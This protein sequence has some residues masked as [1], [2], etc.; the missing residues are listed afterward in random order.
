MYI[1]QG[2]STTMAGNYLLVSVDRKVFAT[3]DSV[4]QA[5]LDHR[6]R[7]SPTC[8]GPIPHTTCIHSIKRLI[9]SYLCPLLLLIGIQLWLENS[10]D[11]LSLSALHIHPADRAQVFDE[12]IETA[13]AIL[14]ETFPR[15]C[16][17]AIVVIVKI[18][19]PALDRHNI[20][21]RGEGQCNSL[22][23]VANPSIEYYPCMQPS[24][25]P[26]TQPIDQQYRQ[27]FH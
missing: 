6:R 5:I 16:G 19:N 14:I 18:I 12:T 22:F 26:S 15:L 25:P 20:Q 21:Y 3:D 27:Q 2:M 9:K 4:Y 24:S 23:C 17:H 7:T 13:Q 8:D 11:G 10:R 1:G